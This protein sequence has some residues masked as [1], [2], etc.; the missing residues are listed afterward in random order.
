MEPAKDSDPIPQGE[1]IRVRA[2]FT[3]HTSLLRIPI[4]ASCSVGSGHL[5]GMARV[6]VVADIFLKNDL[7]L[8]SLISENARVRLATGM[9]P[10]VQWT[11]ARDMS[12]GYWL[13]AGAVYRLNR[14][15]AL[16]VEP[17]L[18]GR[19]LHRDAQGQPLPTPAAFGGQVGVWYGW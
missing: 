3:E 16:S 18:T 4:L 19:F 1:I 10:A 7:Q 5:L 13:S 6:G 8:S 14:H 9:R 11:P 2:T 12:F 15:I 17:V